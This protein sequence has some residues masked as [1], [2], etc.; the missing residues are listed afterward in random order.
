[1]KKRN[2]ILSAILASAVMCS[3]I[4]FFMTTGNAAYFTD[5]SEWERTNSDYG[6]IHAKVTNTD[7]KFMQTEDNQEFTFNQHL[8]LEKAAG[9]AYARFNSLT[10]YTGGTNT[11]A[12]LKVEEYPEEITTNGTGE[13]LGKM[14]LTYSW[15]ADNDNAA[16]VGVSNG[17]IRAHD[18]RG[19]VADLSGCPDYQWDCALNFVVVHP[20]D[21]PFGEIKTNYYWDFNWT[22][23]DVGLMGSRTTRQVRFA[24]DIVITDV[25]E[26][27][28]KIDEFK[29]QIADFE[30]GNSQNLDESRYLKLKKFVNAVPGDMLNG[31]KF[32]TQS[33]VDSMYAY[34]TET[35]EG[36]ADYTD[37]YQI[38]SKIS[39]ITEKSGDNYIYGNGYT[40]E[41]LDEV[42]S[43]LSKIDSALNKSLLLAQQDVVDEA[44]ANLKSLLSELVAK[45]FYEQEMTSISQ[46]GDVWDLA[47]DKLENSWEN[48]EVDVHIIGTKYTYIQ[49]YDDQQFNLYQWL[50]MR[51]RLSPPIWSENH[52]VLKYFVFDTTNTCS[53]GICCNSVNGQVNNSGEFAERIAEA[54]KVDTINGIGYADWKYVEHDKRYYRDKVEEISNATALCNDDGTITEKTIG[55]NGS[56]ARNT[57]LADANIIFKGEGNGVSSVE[58]DLSYVWK[59]GVDNRDSSSNLYHF[60]VPVEVLVTDARDLVKLYDELKELE[61]D[62][63]ERL[64]YTESS[65]NAVTPALAAIPEDLIYGGKYYTQTEVDSYYNQLS[66][67]KD[68]LELL[69]DYTEYDKAYEEALTRNNNDAKYEPTAFSSYMATVEYINANL[70]RRLGETQQNVVDEATKQLNDLMTILEQNAFCDYSKLDYLIEY[71][72]SKFPEYTSQE[73]YSEEIYVAMMESLNNAKA[74]DREMVKGV[75]GANQQIID[76]ATEELLYAIYYD[77]FDSASKDIIKNNNED[78]NDNKVYLDEEFEKF[79]EEYAE[80]TSELEKN[81]AD[82][83]T[84]NHD[85]FEKATTDLSNSHTKLEEAKF[86][87]LTDI[88]NA[89]EDAKELTNDGFTDSSWNNLQDK[90]KEAEDLVA[91][92]PVQGENGS[93]TIQVEKAIEAITDAQNKLKKKADYTAFNKAMESAEAIIN[94]TETVYT[95]SSKNAVLEAYDAAK[96]L[97]KDLP[98]EEQE[99]ITKL[100]E[101]LS[102]AVNGIKVKA[103]YSEFEKVLEDAET[104]LNNGT[105]YT[106]DTKQALL[107]AL[108]NA[109]NVNDDLSEDDQS[110]IDDACVALKTAK[111]GLVE[112]ADTDDYEDIMTEADKIISEGNENGRYDD[113]IWNDFVSEV[114]GAKKTVGDDFDNIPKTEQENVDKFTE[115]L[116]ETVTEV[117]NNRHIIVKFQTEKGEII[118]SY[119]LKSDE[120]KTIGELEALPEAPENTAFK[121]YTGWLYADKTEMSSDDLITA[122]ITLYYIEEEIKIVASEESGAFINEENDFFKGLKHG[123]TVENL[124]S[125]LENDLDYI[126]VK[127]KDGNTVEN[128]GIIATGMTV[129]LISKAD[130]TVKNEVVTVVVEGDINGDGLVNDDD[131]NKSIDMCL[132]NTSYSETEKAYFDANDV[133][134]DGVLD[135]LDL[136]YISNM[137]YGN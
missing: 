48:A 110:I 81:V 45:S 121:K 97:D 27:R 41:S 131:F 129:E 107:S 109:K 67:V 108:T 84:S 32:Y 47:N 59:F 33:E 103:D 92:N 94:D 44:T 70:D 128:T 42:S 8:S 46:G 64:K 115:S 113:D 25:R 89:I 61:G 1:M 122:D 66:G 106:G 62:E 136:F 14:N 37:Y 77:Y 125:A 111:D 35:V 57:Y 133:D 26:L 38:R 21:E 36:L 23:A 13:L 123:T 68:S 76:A 10:L 134:D 96:K 102:T 116:T 31:N 71:A 16:D 3:S 49:T 56:W 114:T 39:K 87:D 55:E 24:T 34:I 51:S 90:I 88:K 83:T 93:G 28:N 18:L 98:E 22:Y 117:K 105:K 60:H 58:Q 132:K 74:I 126:V 29:T 2:K 17:D 54:S 5:G 95:N 119:R 118:K 104:L 137:R 9:E 4:P 101:N 40:K 43:E 63:E 15:S 72:E 11:D 65:I 20:D 86:V 99:S 53:D 69:A 112:A 85:D 100:A 12:S 127:D 19:T 73:N 50:F 30:N 135:A 124:L 52:P 80:I 120:S 130:K 82:E 7:Y 6:K 75:D 91:T 79:K 78:E